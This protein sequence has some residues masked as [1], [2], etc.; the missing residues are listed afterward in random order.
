MY[1]TIGL[2]FIAEPTA[3]PVN[4]AAMGITLFL[5][6]RQH[7][8][9]CFVSTIIFQPLHP[10]SKRSHHYAFLHSSLLLSKLYR[11]HIWYCICIEYKINILS[12][13]FINCSKIISIAF[14]YTLHL[15]VVLFVNHNKRPLW[16]PERKRNSLTKKYAR[17]VYYS[18]YYSNFV[19][20]Y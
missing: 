9:R 3:I 16:P 13:F 10:L 12:H 20:D 5:Q 2:P 15:P 17:I 4:Q 8:F 1:S 19:K 7:S 6:T 18:N 11:S 14:T